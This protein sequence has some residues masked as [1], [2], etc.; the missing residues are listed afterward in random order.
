MN[1][2][3]NSPQE[4]SKPE[5]AADALKAA[6]L[7]IF[8]KSQRLPPLSLLKRKAEKGQS[9]NKRRTGL[10]PCPPHAFE[11]GDFYHL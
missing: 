2:E 3:N 8:K 5:T 4:N 9:T 7:E 6:A 10:L 1:T 11:F